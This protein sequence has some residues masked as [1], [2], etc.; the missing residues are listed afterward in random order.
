[1]E[2][3]K[4]KLAFLLQFAVLVLGTHQ[5][6]VKQILIEEP[7]RP[8]AFVMKP[9]FLIYLKPRHFQGKLII[10]NI[11]NA[12]IAE[13]LRCPV[14]AGAMMRLEPVRSRD[15][16]TVA[17]CASAKVWAAEPGCAAGQARS[18]RKVCTS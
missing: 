15:W 9:S 1:M 6:A 4:P 14:H 7:S 12:P 2:N 16:R 5:H 18:A 3:P 10:S 17:A 8:A 11:K 13:V